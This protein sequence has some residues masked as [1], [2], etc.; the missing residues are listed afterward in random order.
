MSHS[1]R[2]M[3][4]A[5]THKVRRGRQENSSN[6][7]EEGKKTSHNSHSAMGSQKTNYHSTEEYKRQSIAQTVLREDE[8]R[9]QPS[10][11]GDSAKLA[12]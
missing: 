7:T 10:L 6:F 11:L 2:K 3:T 8:T 5:S 9:G 12:C 1:E 4:T